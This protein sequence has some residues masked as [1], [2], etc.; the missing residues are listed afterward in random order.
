MAGVDLNTIRELMGHK[1][2]VMRLWYAHL[3]AGPPTRCRAA[4][5]PAGRRFRRWPV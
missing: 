5:Q 4:P 1:I 3:V 2:L